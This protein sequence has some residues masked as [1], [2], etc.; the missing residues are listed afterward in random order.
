MVVGAPQIADDVAARRTAVES[1]K[2]QIEALT[3]ILQTSVTSVSHMLSRVPGTP[4]QTQMPHARAPAKAAQPAQP[5]AAAAAPVASAA[6][7]LARARPAAAGAALAAP[8]S[9]RAMRG[10][11]AV[12]A[13]ALRRHSFVAAF[14]MEDATAFAASHDS[15]RDVVGWYCLDEE[16]AFVAA[17]AARRVAAAAATGVSLPGC[18]AESVLGNVYSQAGGGSRSGA[19]P[20]GGSVVSASLL[21]AKPAVGGIGVEPQRGDV[22][23][24]LFTVTSDAVADTVVRHRCRLRNFGSISINIF[25]VLSDTEEAQRRALWPAF[26]AA[27]AAGKRAQFHR[28]RLM[29]DVHARSHACMRLHG[30]QARTSQSSTNSTRHAT[31]SQSYGAMIHPKGRQLQNNPSHLLPSELIDRCIGSRI[32]V[33]MKGDKEII[34]TLRGFDVYVNMVLED[35]TE[36]ETTPEGPKTTHLDQILLNGN[37]IAVLV[38]E[39]LTV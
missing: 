20:A 30:A 4:M 34:G 8:T 27:K 36:I 18:L 33:V 6:G 37:N 9:S 24:V 29:I 26:V 19:E 32:W 7:A 22:L 13:A 15:P 11:P 12:A 31:C 3:G 35:V 28:A 39:T 38:P 1:Q 25:D 10:L 21:N 2:Q 16:P 14:S 23:R 5:T 17:A